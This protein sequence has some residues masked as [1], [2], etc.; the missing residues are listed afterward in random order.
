MNC[1]KCG[2]PDQQGAFC[3]SCGDPLPPPPPALGVA[4]PQFGAPAPHAPD[5]ERVDLPEHGAKTRVR[6]LR[7]WLVIAGSFA[8][9]AAVA[10]GS[11]LGWS[12]ASGYQSGQV[13]ESAKV[14]EVPVPRYAADQ[15]VPMPDVRGLDEDAARE[16]LSDQGIPADTV[17]VST[18]EAAGNPG[19][20]IEQTPSFGTINPV[21]VALVVSVEAKVPDVKGKTGTEITEQL[22]QLGAQVAVQLR[23]VA[24]ATPGAVLE[25]SPVVGSPL[26][27]AVA[28]VV[29]EPSSSVYLADLS[30]VNGGCSTGEYSVNG[31]SYANS[32]SCTG[33]PPTA[34]SKTEFAWVTSRAVDSVT[35]TVGISD[36]ADPASRIQLEMFADGVAVASVTAGYGS[37][38][39]LTATTTGALRISIT[40]TDLT[41]GTGYSSAAAILGDVRL[42]GGVEPM[43]Q[44]VVK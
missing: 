30:A 27:D 40:V 33:S 12:L 41:A 18:R 9:T 38:A 14:I 28:L 23:Y 2:S 7:R 24:G 43:K 15:Q 25:I 19:V 35:G 3:V 36:S 1:Q 44:L 26:P 31:A 6:H 32:L 39:P 20:V 16:V 21:S 13:G 42:V 37:P 34:T 11:V 22:S 5:P 8:L 4:A 10:G 17:E 29:A